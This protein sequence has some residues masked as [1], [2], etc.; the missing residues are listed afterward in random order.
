MAE[1][2]VKLSEYELPTKVI[3][4]NIPSSRVRPFHMMELHCKET[5]ED[6][7]NKL[8]IIQDQYKEPKPHSQKQAQGKQLKNRQ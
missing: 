1:N 7:L 8:L 3:T 4:R 6:M 5:M 2:A